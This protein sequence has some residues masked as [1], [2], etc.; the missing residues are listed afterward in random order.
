MYDITKKSKPRKKTTRTHD[1]QKKNQRK[2]TKKNVV[3]LQNDLLHVKQKKNLKKCGSYFVNT[4]IFVKKF[5]VLHYASYFI[6]LHV[7]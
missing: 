1:E 6:I 2:K 3:S 7:L 4:Y 5:Q